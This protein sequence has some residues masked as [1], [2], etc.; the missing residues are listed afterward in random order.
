MKI[1]ITVLSISIALA[2]I[3]GFYFKSQVDALIGD[4]IIGIS[5]LATSFILMPLFI[6]HRWRGKDIR[7]YMLTPENLKKM[8]QKGGF[9]EKDA[10]NQ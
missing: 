10:E 4:R 9:K 1:V 6:F 2:I 7:N 5:I 3:T 8:G